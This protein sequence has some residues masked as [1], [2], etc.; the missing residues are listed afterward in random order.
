MWAPFL[1]FA[2]LCAGLASMPRDQ[3]ASVPETPSFVRHIVPLFQK[4]GCSSI[5]CHGAPHGQNGF[6]L[7]TLGRYPEQDI[8]SLR[9]DDRVNSADV[10]S[11]LILQKPTL[12]LSHRGGLRFKS[13]SWEHQLLQRWIAQ[14]A[15]LDSAPAV[16]SLAIEPAKLQF[17]QASEPARLRILATRLNGSPEDV[18]HLVVLTS[19]DESI[20]SVDRDT[21]RIRPGKSSGVAHVVASYGTNTA[22]CTVVIPFAPS[23]GIQRLLPRKSP[24]DEFIGQQLQ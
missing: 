15:A 12:E 17:S 18:S 13:G 11:S 1:P 5:Q 3:L 8:G 9:T 2:V 20:V 21:G 23:K 4:L 22:A 10:D 14:G 6:R 24:I 7:S 19:T 16:Q